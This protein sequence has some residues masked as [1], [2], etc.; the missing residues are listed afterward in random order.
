MDFPRLPWLKKVV[1]EYLVTRNQ[2]GPFHFIIFDHDKYQGPGGGGD[3]Y[4]NNIEYITGSSYFGQGIG[5]PLLTSPQYNTNGDI[6]FKN[7]R[8]RA[9]HLA[10]EGDLSPMVSYRLRYTLMNSWGKPYAP[11]L[12]NKRSNSGQVE[13]KYHHPRLQGWEF[14]GAVAADAGSL[15]GDNVG[16]SL[17]V[18]KRDILKSWK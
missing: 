3:D 18:C 12:N 1:T 10:F 17:S 15:Y 11:F 6:D 14:T 16:F 13:V 8:V 9:W 4:Y 2:S 7:T 5:S